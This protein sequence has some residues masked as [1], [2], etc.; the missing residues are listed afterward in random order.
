MLNFH[1]GDTQCDVAVDEDDIDE[2]E[3]GEMLNEN[4]FDSNDNN[5]EV[6]LSRMK[7][8]FLTEK[9]MG[10]ISIRKNGKTC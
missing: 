4:E 5:T 6:T 2:N 8:V 3:E 7:Q 9:D 1:K 10:C